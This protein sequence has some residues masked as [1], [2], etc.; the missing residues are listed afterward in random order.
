MGAVTGMLGFGGGAS[1]TG[2]SGPSGADIQKPITNAI[3][4]QAN[5]GSQNALAAQQQLM[6][7]LQGQGGI[8]HQSDIYN[9]LQGIASGQGPNPA[10]A[11]LSEATRQNVAQQAALMGSQ[12]GASANPGLL[13]RQAAMQGGNIQQQAANQAAMLQANQQ[14]GALG[15]AGQLANA[16]V[17]N[18][19]GQMNTGTAAQQQQQQMLLNAINGQ[20]TNEVSSR[21]NVN[22]ANA[23]LA[24]SQMGNQ[25]K[26]VGGFM[27]AAGAALGL[28]HGGSVPMADG[29]IAGPQSKFARF[30]ASSSPQQ[31]ASDENAG[32][33][34]QGSE[35]PLQKGSA[36]LTSGLLGKLAG[37]G[38]GSSLMAGGAM[39]AGGASALAGLAVAAKGGDVGSQLKSGG[40]VPGKPQVGGARDSYSNDNVH[41]LLSPGEIV[42]PRSVTMSEDPVSESAKF[43][44]SVLAKRKSRGV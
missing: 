36:A 17:A 18:Q 30:L 1:G 15:Q 12:R 10:L 32:F 40:H 4:D 14:L 22:N 33:K 31:Q 13:A 29:G 35:D 8:G 43:V 34:L 37:G 38:K 27:Q 24:Q 25:G 16:Q 44:A 26:M 2:F 21:N 39:D 11:Q 19:I 28:A 5:L 20:N 3:A 42:L 6:M 7:A 23:G 9:Q 41:A